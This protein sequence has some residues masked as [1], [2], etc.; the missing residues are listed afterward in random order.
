MKNIF[1]GFALAISMLTTVPF[2]KVHDFDK[3][4]NGYS[5]MFYPFVGFLLGTVL[6]IIYTFLHSY[7]PV[8]HLGILIFVFWVVLTGALH[9][10]GFS[11]TVDGL[12]VAKEKALQVMKDPN[13]GGMGMIFTVT[14]LILKASVLANFE[15][16]YLLPIVL[17]LS[18]LSV[19]LA[20]YNYPYISPSG[21]S[22][23]AKMELKKGQVLI[24]VLYSAFL[25]TLFHGWILLMSSLLILLVIKNFFVKRYAGFT[26][27]IYGFSIEVIELI[28]LNII[29]IGT[30]K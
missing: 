24:A 27:D 25:V 17:M 10:D 9:L 29:L 8:S 23:L 7:F 28:L 3:G 16:F 18:R 11:D 26:G 22:T 20:I 1:N 2:F 5:V 15:A 13:T 14:F 12:Y 30:F 21:M 19:V 6:Y 4:I